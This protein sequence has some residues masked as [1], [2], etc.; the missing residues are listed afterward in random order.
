MAIKSNPQGAIALKHAAV[1][2][3][4]VA[5]G[6]KSAHSHSLSQAARDAGYSEAYIRSGKLQKT[7]AWQEVIHDSLPDE[8]LL[9]VHGEQLEANKLRVIRFDHRMTDDEI[10]EVL[11]KGECAVVSIKRSETEAYVHFA[12]PDYLTRLRALDMAYKLKG[13]YKQTVVIQ[14]QYRKLNDQELEQEI[15]NTLAEA[16][17]L[18]S[19][20]TVA[21]G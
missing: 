1:L 6:G 16:L 5:N 9:R 12:V 13:R 19:D 18:L 8:K 20:D 7:K 10:R 15:A 2:Q 4:M 21:L 14:G 11:K 17:E 3:K